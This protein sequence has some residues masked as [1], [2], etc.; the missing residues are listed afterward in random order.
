MEVKRYEQSNS[1]GML[2]R[3]PYTKIHNA[4]NTAVCSFTIAVKRMYASGGQQA[5]FINIVVWDKTAEF[6]SKY[7]IKGQR[8]AVVGRIQTRSYE[9]AEG[10]KIFVV[11]VVAE[12]AF[13]AD[14][15]KEG[16][17]QTRLVET[18]PG[19]Y[20]SEDTELPF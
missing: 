4:K 5:D 7:F 13:F 6:C 16:Q 19:E 2:N 20:V 15:K 3:R 8:V 12:E 10:K 17:Q 1:Y 14:S 9:N 11:E 18:E